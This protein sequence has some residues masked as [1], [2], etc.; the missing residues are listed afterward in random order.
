MTPSIRTRVHE[1]EVEN[2]LK[3]SGLF[4]Q[5]KDD[6]LAGQS[7]IFDVFEPPCFCQ[8][9][10]ILFLSL[11]KK[12]FF[13]LNPNKGVSAKKKIGGPKKTLFFVC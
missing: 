1:G 3:W 8:N 4:D 12:L 13:F 5:H 7:V 6:W 11:S 10:S 2:V 9:Y